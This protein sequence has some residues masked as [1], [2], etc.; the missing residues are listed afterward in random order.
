MPGWGEL[1]VEEVV[2]KCGEVK[3]VQ[4]M[5]NTS[6]SMFIIL[7]IRKHRPPLGEARPAARRRLVLHVHRL[8][9]LHLPVRTHL[10][11][12]YI[13]GRVSTVKV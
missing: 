6:S 8:P 12:I 5:D 11:A 9:S 3:H 13:M 10:L 7:K 4:L 1:F 2:D